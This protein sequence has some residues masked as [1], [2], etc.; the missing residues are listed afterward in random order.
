MKKN[1]KGFTL[2]EILVVVLIIGILAAIALPQ[3]QASVDKSRFVTMMDITNALW[4]AEERNYMIHDSYTT[5]DKLDIDLQDCTLSNYNKSCSFDWGT[6]EIYDNEGSAKVTCINNTQLNNAYSRH[7]SSHVEGLKIA[8]F[9]LGTGED[10]IK[11][12]WKRVCK[13][14]GAR[15]KDDGTCM[16]LIGNKSCSKFYF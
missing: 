1:V 15:Y 7:L 6:C 16:L 5:L 14:I 8:C 11:E 9:A 10:E 4:E 12:R 3:Y 13:N 2:V